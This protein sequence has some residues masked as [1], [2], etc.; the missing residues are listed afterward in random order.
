M[1]TWPALMCWTTVAHAA[2]S[3]DR[4]GRCWL[5]TGVGTQMMT[6]SAALAAAGSVVS[7]RLPSAS[8]A[9]SRSRSGPPRSAR[10]AAMSRSRC[11]LLSIPM[12]C[13]TSP[14]SATAVGSPTYPNPTIATE[15]A[16]TQ[17]PFPRPA[18]AARPAVWK[19][20]SFW[21]SRFSRPLTASE[22]RRSATMP[23]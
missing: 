20:I 14:C 9:A 15:P 12:I 13:R 23:P 3:A 11:G 2:R 17:W 6:A 21:S 1:M 22:S 5:S 16:V 19:V 4:S 8:A 10:R 7:S 18:P